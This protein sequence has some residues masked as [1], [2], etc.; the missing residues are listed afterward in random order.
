MPKTDEQI[1]QH[2]FLEARS[3]VLGTWEEEDLK[4]A[5]EYWS[6]QELES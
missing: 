3:W 4:K 2:I 5:R 6:L 1:S